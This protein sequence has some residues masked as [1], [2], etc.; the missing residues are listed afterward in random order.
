M[1]ADLRWT[2]SD[3]DLLS[4]G[5]E[6]V[7]IVVAIRDMK[8]AQFFTEKVVEVWVEGG[9]KYSRYFS[10]VASPSKYPSMGSTCLGMQT[11]ITIAR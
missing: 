7:H 2:D 1:I 8:E 9:Y 5:T 4:Q 10:A 11:L 3:F 6:T